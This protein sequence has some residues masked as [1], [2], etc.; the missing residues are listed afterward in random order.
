MSSI[1]Q[2]INQ[3]IIWPIGPC[4]DL[5]VCS[6][7]F[8]WFQPPFDGEDEEE[9]FSSITDHSMSYPKSLSRESIAICKGVRYGPHND[10]YDNQS[11]TPT[12]KLSSSSSS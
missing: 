3:S 11:P 6:C 9:L 12:T 8:V 10:D 2:S 7:L 5:I 1:N 4:I